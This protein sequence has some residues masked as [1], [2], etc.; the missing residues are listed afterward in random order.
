MPYETDDLA[1]VDTQGDTI[2]GSHSAEPA[3]DLMNNK[4]MM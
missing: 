1:F 3:S 4:C 2:Q